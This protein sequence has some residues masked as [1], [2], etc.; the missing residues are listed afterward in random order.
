VPVFRLSDEI[1]FPDARLAD[2]DG[3]L[4]VGGDLRPERLLLAYALGIFPWYEEEPILWHSPDPRWVLE[5]GR[6]HVPRRL[7]RTLRQGVFELRLDADFPA[8]IG[9][10]AETRRRGQRG[11][12][13]TPAMRDAYLR[14]HELGFAHSA[15]AFCGGEL[16]GGVYGVSLGAAFFGESMFFRRR[17]ASKAALVALAWQLEAWGFA[18]LDCQV[19]TGHLERL[20]ATSWP[21][22]RFLAA[23]AKALEAPTRRGPWRLDPAALRQRLAKSPRGPAARPRV[24]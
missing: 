3:L 16:V 14:L 11:T 13:I 21:R 12:W 22:E 19:H 8:V 18:L 10:C 17:D 24:S 1:A 15:E 6:L 23:L 5:P 9:A 2:P 20:G 7:L 4:A